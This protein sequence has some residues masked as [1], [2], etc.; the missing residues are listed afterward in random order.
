MLSM[1]RHVQD[2]KEGSPDVKDRPRAV[3]LLFSAATTSELVFKVS[4]EFGRQQEA[5]F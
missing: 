4:V 5:R 1:L 3:R 2:M